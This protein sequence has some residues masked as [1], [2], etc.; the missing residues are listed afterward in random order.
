MIILA[1]HKNG[2]R[3]HWNKGTAS[4]MTMQNISAP[5]LNQELSLPKKP[6]QIKSE[7]GSSL[8]KG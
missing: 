6:G 5:G 2:A 1:L 8:L 3:K 7:S 4:L